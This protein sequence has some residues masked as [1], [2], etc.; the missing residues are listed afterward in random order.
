MNIAFWDNQLCERGTTVALYD[1]AYN[2]EKF[3]NNKSYIFYINNDRN[4]NSEIIEKFKK[5]FIVHG[6]NS[7]QEVDEYLKKYNIS[8]IYIIKSGQLDDRISKVAKNC[9]HC[10]F[11][12]SEPHGDIY[13]SIA[14]WVY[15]NNGKIPVVPHM[16][17]LPEHNENWRNRLNIPKSAIIFGGYGGEDNFSIPFAKQVV[18]EIARNNPNIY[19]LFANF[20]QFCPNLPNIIHLPMITDVNDKVAFINTTDAMLWARIH[21]ETFGLAIAEFS[22]KNKPVIAMNIGDSSHYHLLGDK[23]LWYN[24]AGS[25]TDLLMNFKPSP[26]SDWNAFKEYTPEKVMEIFKNVYLS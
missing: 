2:N 3:L 4:N 15:A 16:V 22:S 26:E 21:G 13:S 12:C 20:R 23:G 1:Y 17:D 9:I 18:Y 14:P 7:F 10:V 24:D 6:V 5:K 11:N 19:F 8:H 25:L